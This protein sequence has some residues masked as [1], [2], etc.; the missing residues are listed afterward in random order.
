M[1]GAPGT[2]DRRSGSLVFGVLAMGAPFV[3]GAALI[4]D[5]PEPVLEVF[6]F[7]DP[8]IVESS[9]LVSMGDLVVTVNDSGDS[10]R[11]FAV[12]PRTGDTV[13]TT[14][15]VEDP[16]D[17]EAVAPASAGQVW[18]ADIGDNLARRDSVTLTRVR[19]GRGD[20]QD[21]GTTW[22]L[23]YADGA[24][25]A[26]TLLVHPGTGRL[27]VVTKG[28]FGGQVYAAP[29]RL[30]DDR[31]NVLRP[32]EPALGM[33]TDGAFFP[34][35]QHVV[36]RNYDRAVIYSWPS[37]TE[38]TELG[39]PRQE[40]GEGIAVTADNRVLLSSEGVDQPVLEV[41]LPTR[42]Q[43]VVSGESGSSTTTEQEGAVPAPSA[44][45]D[46]EESVD[47][48]MEPSGGDALPYL[49]GGGLLALVLGG[50]LWMRRWRHG[51][52]RRTG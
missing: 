23:T 32:G 49:V 52:G 4:G 31:P 29:T 15:F 27:F 47:P 1:R 5:P 34:D 39:L 30:R 8:A 40:Q 46:S 20:R 6:R 48:A 42:L 44:P 2:G 7:T 25:N 22:T 14:S 36:V 28:V 17:I 43:E 24:H 50:L 13:G 37:M 11:V 26:E 45:D 19:V 18:V 9:G 35:G 3:V 12:D 41:P 38:V 16:V 10:G 51:A 33:A 21:P